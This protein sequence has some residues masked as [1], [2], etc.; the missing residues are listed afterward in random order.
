MFF[1]VCTPIQYFKFFKIK[2][3]KTNNRLNETKKKQLKLYSCKTK[4]F[5]KKIKKIVLNA[6]NN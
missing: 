2:N 1:S 6:I 3:S 5:Y 4:Y